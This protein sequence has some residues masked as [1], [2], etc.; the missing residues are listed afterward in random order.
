MAHEGI[1]LPIFQRQLGHAHLGI[2]S[3]YLRGIDTRE[4]VDMVH[5][6][7]APVIPQAPAC[8]DGEGRKGA[9]D[10]RIARLLFSPDSS[11]TIALPSA[12]DVPVG[13]ALVARVGGYIVAPHTRESHAIRARL[14][15]AFGEQQ[16]SQSRGPDDGLSGVAVY[17]SMAGRSCSRELCL[18]QGR[19]IASN[20]R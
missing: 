2:T 15:A 4:I 18:Q 7:R 10:R 1:P 8:G 12:T 11:S 6:R 20:W 17:R 16:P 19:T 3:I 9:R 13:E 5:H 14:V